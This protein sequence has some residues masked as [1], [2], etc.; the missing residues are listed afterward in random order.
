VLFEE[1]PADVV[2]STESS[3]PATPAVT[4]PSAATKKANDEAKKKYEKDNKI[5]R[6]HLL[7]HMANNLFDLFINQKSSKAI[8]E[9]LVK[10]Y[11]DDDAGKKKYVVGNW[12]RFQMVDNK[13]IMEQIHEY[14]NLVGEVLNEGMKMCEILQANVLLE[15]FPRSWSDY[16]NQLKHKKRDLSLQELINRMKT[17]E[18]NRLKDKHVSFSTNSVNVD[19]VEFVDKNRFKGKGKRFQK[20]EQR[21]KQ[22]GLKKGDN[23]IQKRTISC[24]VCGKSG[25]KAYQ[26]YM[27]QGQQS[28]NQKHAAPSAPQAN[29]AENEE[30]IAAVVVEANLVDNKVDWIL[31]TGASK[32]LC[33]NKELFHQIE[34]VADGERV[35]MGNSATA[36]VFGKG[37]ILLKLTSGKTISLSD[38][39]YVPSLRRNLIFGSLLNR[40]GLKL[41]FEADKVV[42][43]KNG[44]LVGKGYQA[45]DLFVLNTISVASNNM[46]S[47]ASVYIDEYVNLWHGRLGHVNVNS[48]KKLRDM[49]LINVLDI[50]QFS[51]CPICIEAKYAKKPFKHVTNRSTELLELV[52]SDLADFKNSVSRGGKRYYV[53]FIDDFSRYI[54][55]YLLNSKDEAETM[56]LKYKAEVENQLDRK[57]KRIRSDRGGEYGTNFLREFCEK[58]G[59]VHETSAP[60]TPQQNGISERKNR[61]LKEMMNAMLLSSG[62]SNQM[63]GEVVLSAC[64]TLNRVPHKRLDKT[65][66]ELWKGFAPNLNFLKVWGCLAKV[67]LPDFKRNN[68]G[69]KTFDFVYWICSK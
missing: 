12:L 17:E 33:A 40:A 62:M 23:N 49:N 16:R 59:I 52:H 3:T 10:R 14:E 6:G 31:D 39:L 63:W 68:V 53:T 5:A 32:H 45:D 15:K 9:F 24:Y 7:N 58:N 46:S 36:G 25:H 47:V 38:V 48:I 21:N 50:N 4:P 55:V 19:V 43:T 54:K 34:D 64:Y 2:D 65:P 26:C 66:Y 28:N 18:A 30:V 22:V 60:Y 11:G 69:T 20:N 1:P 61:T 67:G 44:E 57:I 35:F 41:V 37:K 56:F 51:K 27:K 13:P 29:L 8:W 42:I